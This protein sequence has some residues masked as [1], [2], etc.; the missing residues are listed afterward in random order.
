MSQFILY[1]K[2]NKFDYHRCFIN[3][4]LYHTKAEHMLMGIYYG[5]MWSNP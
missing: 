4:A 2:Y 1:Q 5:I 3:M